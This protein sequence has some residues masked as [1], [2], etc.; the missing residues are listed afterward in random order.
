MILQGNQHVQLDNRGCV[1]CAAQDN[2][3]HMDFSQK[4]QHNNYLQK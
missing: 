4:F 1:T 2:Q 3:A